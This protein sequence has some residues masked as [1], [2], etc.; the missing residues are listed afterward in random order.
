MVTYEPESETLTS[1]I[2]E[3]VGKGDSIQKHL[4]PQRDGRRSPNMIFFLHF[5][6]KSTTSQKLKIGNLF[7][8]SFQ[9][10]AHL[11]SKFGNL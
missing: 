11:S 9:L 8:H 2:R 4:G 10:I 6:T 5:S 1:D 7:L 3:P